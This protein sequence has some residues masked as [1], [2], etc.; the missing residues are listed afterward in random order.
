MTSISSI[1][2]VDVG[3]IRCVPKLMTCA[4]RNQRQV[5]IVELPCDRAP[6]A[7]PTPSCRIHIGFWWHSS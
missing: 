3:S 6:H 2:S 1:G 4:V 7:V 5:M